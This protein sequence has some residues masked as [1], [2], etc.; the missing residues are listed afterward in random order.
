[1][2]EFEHFFFV[3]FFLGYVPCAY[4]LYL[5]S[6]MARPKVPVTREEAGVEVS[7]PNR[8]RGGRRP[9][10][11][12]YR[13]EKEKENEDVKGK[14]KVDGNRGRLQLHDEGSN[15]DAGRP[16][17]LV[18]ARGEEEGHASESS[19]SDSSAAGNTIETDRN[20]GGSSSGGAGHNEGE[21]S[22][23]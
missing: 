21:R 4:I 23:C 1:M 16:E 20:V 10:T 6:G 11:A 18:V 7:R 5:F 3:N 12:S 22:A 15:I 9:P 14:A 2:D 17:D 13:K 8:G 19:S